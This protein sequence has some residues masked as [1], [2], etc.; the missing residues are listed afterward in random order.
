[1]SDISR[2]VEALGRNFEYFFDFMSYGPQKHFLHSKQ[3]ARRARKHLLSRCRAIPSNS[4][5]GRF[6][7]GVALCISR[8]CHMGGK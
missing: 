1:M 7:Q 6:D 5:T 4:D 2:G 3:Y 8:I